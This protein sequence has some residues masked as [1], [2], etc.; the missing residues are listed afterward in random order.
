MSDNRASIFNDA[1]RVVIKVGS[2][3]LTADLGLNLK[4]IRS[5]SGQIC[6]L[7]E[8]GREVVLVTGSIALII[9]PL[10]SRLGV[11]HVVAPSLVESNG[12]FTGELDGPPISDEEKARRVRQFAGENH[13][14]LSRSHAYGDS[15]ADLPML[16]T[17]G[18]PHAVN[19]DKAL[20]AAAHTRGWPI[21][22]W[23]VAR[24]S[25]DVR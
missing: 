1:R 24:T 10:A 23:S 18:F 4:A 15:I 11:T 12:R 6:R 9:E 13:I 3:V 5:I 19:P 8:D 20:A 7:I 22:Q 25:A 21:H 14:D 2:N 16:E 17:V